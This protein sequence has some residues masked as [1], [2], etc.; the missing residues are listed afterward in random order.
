MV[1]NAASICLLVVK[2]IHSKLQ[3]KSSTSVGDGSRLPKEKHTNG[4]ANTQVALY[5]RRINILKNGENFWQDRPGTQIYATLEI[6]EW[7]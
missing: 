4:W 2:K 7:I 5:L 1:E 3:V 6:W